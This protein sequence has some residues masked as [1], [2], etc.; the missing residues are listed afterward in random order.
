MLQGIDM[1]KSLYLLVLLS[2]A[3]ITASYGGPMESHTNYNVILVHG[4]GD[5]HNA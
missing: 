5:R 2:Q 1:K 4:A 3:F